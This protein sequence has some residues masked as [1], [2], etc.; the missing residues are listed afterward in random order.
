MIQYLE[1]QICNTKIAIKIV[2]YLST[3]FT[4]VIHRYEHLIHRDNFYGNAFREL[5]T[6]GFGNLD[7][8]L[9][10]NSLLY[11]TKVKIVFNLRFL[12]EVAHLPC[13]NPLEY[14]REPVGYLGTR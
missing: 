11:K 3:G 2:L 9:P 13:K 7:T 4:E 5:K 8:L 14:R 1:S 6:I 12:L 10:V